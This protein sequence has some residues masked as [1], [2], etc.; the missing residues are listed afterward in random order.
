MN[1]AIPPGGGPL[2]EGGMFIL[3]VSMVVVWGISY[4][5]RRYLARRVDT[6]GWD[7][8]LVLIMGFSGFVVFA[9]LGVSFLFGLAASLAMSEGAAFV[10]IV[11][12]GG[13]LAWVLLPLDET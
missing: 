7:L 10:L 1:D 3:F 12:F 6:E 2:P 9:I 8:L 11:I 5:L 4:R 13:F